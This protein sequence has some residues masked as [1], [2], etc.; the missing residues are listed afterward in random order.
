MKTVDL[1][2]HSTYSDGT[3]TPT[4]LVDEAL[5]M[6]LS[7]MALTDH[8]TVAGIPEAIEAGNQKGL[9]IIPGIEI[10]TSYKDKEIHIVG[11]FLDYENPTFLEAIGNERERRANRNE[12]LIERF[13]EYGFAISIEELEAL[14]PNSVITRAH[15]AAY[16]VLKGYVKTR[17]EAFDKYLGDG[18]PL[19]IPR[20]RKTPEQ[21]MAAIQ[22]AGGVAV[23]AH[24]LLY[25]LT[26]HE[27]KELCLTCKKSGLA[28]IETMYST[29]KGF[30]ELTV[31]Q[32]A[33]EV[34]LLESGGSDF[35]GANK[36]HIKLGV[37]MN[38]LAISYSFLEA[39]RA[40]K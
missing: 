1:H 12:K 25:H 21:A 14:Y 17:D 4:Q 16:M 37:G 34:G 22:A 15:F 6:G 13:Q 35:H 32:L 5:R 30:D 24:P 7:A 29:Y 18:K 26:S 11:L 36:P 40:H 31:R 39:L 8:D 33:H 9:E 20:E 28:G 10:S 2:V 3:L 38:N 27:L 19:Y 23:L